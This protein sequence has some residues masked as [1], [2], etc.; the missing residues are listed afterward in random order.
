MFLFGSEYRKYPFNKLF[1]IKNAK[2]FFVMLIL[3]IIKITEFTK[4]IGSAL[5]AV[6]TR[7]D[8]GL[9]FLSAAVDKREAQL[10]SPQQVVI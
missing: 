7:Q 6:L 9:V 10:L 3:I 1:N 5:N 4:V 2:R 8:I